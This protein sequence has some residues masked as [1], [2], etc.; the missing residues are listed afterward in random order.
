MIYKKI[1]IGLI[2]TLNLTPVLSQS[3]EPAL[4]V[5]IPL[6]SIRLSDPYILADKNTST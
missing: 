1:L 4:K 6:D 2:F 5:D 3:W